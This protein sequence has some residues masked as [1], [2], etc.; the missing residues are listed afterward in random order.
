MQAHGIR[1]ALAERFRGLGGFVCLLIHVKIGILVF[2]CHF[3]ALFLVPGN[4]TNMKYLAVEPV[5]FKIT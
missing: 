4:I 5:G 3:W 2:F 1:A